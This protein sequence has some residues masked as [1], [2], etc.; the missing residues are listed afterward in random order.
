MSKPTHEPAILQEPRRHRYL[1]LIALFKIGQGV[2]LLLLGISLVFLIE[3]TR[4]M[5]AMSRG[6]AVALLLEHSKAVDYLLNKLQAVLAGGT[7]RATGFLALFYTGVLFTEG[8]GVYMEQRWAELLMI[9]ATAAL[10]PLEV[11]HIWH[12][13]GLVGALIL[14]VNCFIVWFLYR[15]L[16]RQAESARRA[17]RRMGRGT[18]HTLAP[19]AQR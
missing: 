11:R 12:H 17:A 6:T 16:K 10:I 14:L 8:I 19:K 7:L 5:V 2:L 15:V 9:F 13:P 18:L 3:R 1:R 4:W